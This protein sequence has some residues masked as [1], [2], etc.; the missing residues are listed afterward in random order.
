MFINTVS[1]S[2]IKAYNECKKKYKFKYI[3][4]LRENYNPNTNTDALQYG[5]FV[6]KV[7]ELGYNAESVE[8]LKEI[9]ESVRDSYTF[10]DAKAFNLD[11][12]L[13]NFFKFNSKLEEHVSSELIFE[14]PVTDDYS[15]NGIIDRVIKGKTGKYL[16]IDY[17]TSRRAATKVEL[18][19]DPQMLMYAF[20]VAKLHNVPIDDVTVSH[21]YPHMDKL[22]SIKYGKTQVGIF[23]PQ[24]K[25][26]IR[27]I[28][29][30]KS[31]DFPASLNQFCDWCQYKELCPE[32][33]GTPL[34][35]E[36]AKGSEKEKRKASKPKVDKGTK[37]G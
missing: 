8:K 23:L 36:E 33:G 2:K 13:H 37:S 6:H 22:I 4:R 16:V 30:K 9:A 5:S 18:Y 21:Y 11:V 17:K 28:R 35:L 34:M 12:I 10:P 25:N 26:K 1:P 20:A 27:E 7:L 32:F 19:K 24:L 31:V 3:D 29:K 15:I 14:I